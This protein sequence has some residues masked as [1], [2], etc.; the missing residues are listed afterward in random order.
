MVLLLLQVGGTSAGQLVA[1][2]G[3]GE[4]FGET[5]EAEGCVCVAGV[6]V[7]HQS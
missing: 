3:P 7:F 4:V 2:L 6:R 5:G 1:S